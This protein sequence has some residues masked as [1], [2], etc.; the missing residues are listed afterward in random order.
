MVERFLFREGDRGL[1]TEPLEFLVDQNDGFR[2]AFRFVPKSLD[3]NKSVKNVGFDPRETFLNAIKT[4][5]D[6]LETAVD[7]L[8]AAVDLLETC[9]D[10][11]ET[12][13]DL[14]ETGVDLLKTAVDLSETTVELLRERA[15]P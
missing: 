14:L 6:L 12:G 2:D 4:A 1:G 3:L 10:L 5:V 8:E 15:E 9:V 13:V 7:L 11:L